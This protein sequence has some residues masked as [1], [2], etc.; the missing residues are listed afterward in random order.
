MPLTPG[1]IVRKKL[2]IV[3]AAQ[4]RLELIF[5]ASNQ[6]EELFVGPAS[7]SLSPDPHPVADIGV[8][9]VLMAPAERVDLRL[10][11]LDLAADDFWPRPGYPR[12][13]TR[14]SAPREL[15]R[16]LAARL[17]RVA[18]MVVIPRLE[19]VDDGLMG[20]SAWGSGSA[21]LAGE[22]FRTRGVARKLKMSRRGKAAASSG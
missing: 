20:V 11:R 17:K 16:T 18:W 13:M 3:L 6:P 12:T 22:Q 10:E 9:E 8:F 7:S 4:E 5:H 1:L 14:S 19:V 15:E 21:E 2:R